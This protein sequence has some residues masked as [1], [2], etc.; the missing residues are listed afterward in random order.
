LSGLHE[1]LIARMTRPIFGGEADFVK[2]SFSRRAGRVT[3]LTAR[4]LL[5]QFFP[6]LGYFEQPLG[7]IVAARRSILRRLRFENDYG[8][9]IGLLLDA[10]AA[11]AVLGEVDIGHIEHDSHPLEKLAS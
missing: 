10:A 4:P 8:V 6:E 3:L 11:G 2:A 5:R 1:E 7:G 9:D